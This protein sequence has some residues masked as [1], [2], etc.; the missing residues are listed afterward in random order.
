MDIYTPNNTGPDME[1]Y[2]LFFFL[3]TYISSQ[4]LK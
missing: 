4:I 3:E 1:S 2:S